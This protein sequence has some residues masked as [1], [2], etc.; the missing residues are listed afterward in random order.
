VKNNKK[1]WLENRFN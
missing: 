1:W